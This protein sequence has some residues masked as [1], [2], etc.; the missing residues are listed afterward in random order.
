[1]KIVRTTAKVMGE[2]YGTLFVEIFG[3]WEPHHVPDHVWLFTEDDDSNIMGFASGCETGPDEIFL[4]WGGCR[5]EYRNA[6]IKKRL[7]QVKDHLHER[8]KY[9]STT[10]ENSNLSMLR[11]YLSIGYLIHGIHYSTDR[12]TYVELISTKGAIRWQQHD[13]TYRMGVS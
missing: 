6:K 9:I 8:Y 2:L 13:L 1:V 12:K 11:L 7:K 4:Q 10:V 5:P 3:K